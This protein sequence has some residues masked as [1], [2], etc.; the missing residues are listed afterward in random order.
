[1]PSGWAAGGT[2]GLGE[3]KL[4]VFQHFAA[5]HHMKVVLSGDWLKWNC[6]RLCRKDL[7]RQPGEAIKEVRWFQLCRY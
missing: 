2:P 1:M 6:N 4:V 3:R 7:T 5:I